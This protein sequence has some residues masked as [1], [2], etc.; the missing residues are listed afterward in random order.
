MTAGPES[1]AK[2]ETSEVPIDADVEARW[3]REAWPAEAAHLRMN[4]LPPIPTSLAIGIV[5]WFYCP[6][7]AVWVMMFALHLSAASAMLVVFLA[8]RAR[9]RPKGLLFRLIVADAFATGQ[10]VPSLMVA[11]VSVFIHGLCML[12]TLVISSFALNIPIRIKLVIHGIALGL[13]VMVIGRHAWARGA[14][15]GAPGEVVAVICACLLVAFTLPLVPHRIRLHQLHAQ[16]ARMNLEHEIVLRKQREKELERLSQVA[17]DARRIAEAASIEAQDASRAKSEFLAAMS[18]EIRTPLNGVIGMSSLLLESKLTDEQREYAAVIRT[19]GQALLSVLGDILDFSKI[20]SGKIEL[21]IRP[22]NF[23]AIIEESLDLFAANAA[24]KGVELAYRFEDGCPETG[25]TDS[26]RLRQILNNLISNAVKF[27]ENGDV[28]IR[29]AREGEAIH[30][31]IQDQGIGIAPDVQN[32]LF[33]PFSQV[34]ASTTRKFGGTGLGLAICKKLVELLGGEIAVESA[35]GQGSM[36]HFTIALREASSVSAVKPWLSGKTAVI[37]DKSAASRD[38]LASMLRPW[39]MQ[40]QCF[41]D[42]DQAF[43]HV[44]AH[45]I[46]VLFVDMATL[47]DPK[48]FLSLPK[49]PPI[50]LVAALH[51]LPAAKEVPNTAGIISKP[52]KRWQLHEALLAAF[53]TNNGPQPATKQFEE[54]AMGQDLQVRVLL[55]EDNRINQKVALKMLA[56][57]GYQAE[58]AVNGAE[59][60]EMVQRSNYDVV[61]MDVQMPILDGLQATRQIRADKLVRMQPWI[62]AMTAEALSGDEA[63]CLEAGMDSYVTKP[64]QIATLAEELRQ[65]I[66]KLRARTT[67]QS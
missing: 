19:S 17:S 45:D 11:Q 13:F 20:E 4:A 44:L 25:E 6:S 10:A 47:S 23:R 59:A 65:G 40:A 66:P 15:Y 31:F 58:V 32:R 1:Q 12:I 21:E 63:R 28:T 41:T 51:R 61:F 52:L 48:V 57:L 42:I 37:V 35:G 60:V 39:G 27:T 36:F 46:Q 67:E 53:G 16:R 3:D 56:K 50:V 43:A 54:L 62:V 14:A 29:V 9:E 26:N 55:V 33:K 38:A 30:F 2:F 8:A 34:D 7:V 5:D 49:L 22:T 64:V 24:E 18:H